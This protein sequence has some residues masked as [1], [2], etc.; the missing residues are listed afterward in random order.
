MKEIK[1]YKN[2]YI[3]LK[4]YRDNEIFRKEIPNIDILISMLEEDENLYER[5]IRDNE[6]Y[7][8]KFINCFENR[9]DDIKWFYDNKDK[10]FKDI[11]CYEDINENKE[12][13][14]FEQDFENYCC[15]NCISLFKRCQSGNY[16]NAYEQLYVWDE[17]YLYTYE[18][19]SPRYE[20]FVTKSELVKDAMLLLIEVINKTYKNYKNSRTKNR[21]IF[22]ENKDFIILLNQ[23]SKDELFIKEIPNVYEV[24]KK[25]EISLLN[26]NEDEA[27]R[28]YWLI[29]DIRDSIRLYEQCR[30][31]MEFF[32]NNRN[33]S[34][35][36]NKDRIEIN[37]DE[38]K[39]IL[40]N[41][42]RTYEKSKKF[43]DIWNYITRHSFSIEINNIEIDIQYEH[44]SIREFIEWVISEINK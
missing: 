36:I 10:Y 1:Y 42:I 35:F 40:L 21:D 13:D 2:H 24:I 4:K 14:N 31:D 7:P 38:Y 3:G 20:D 18:I 5:Y 43:E 28:A 17:I 6:L 15:H 16:M 27:Y 11:I 29:S 23:Y 8:G 32:Y 22:K 33:L 9:K 39:R 25:L 34:E 26:N 30:D 37:K 19:S 44:K 41:Y 12:S